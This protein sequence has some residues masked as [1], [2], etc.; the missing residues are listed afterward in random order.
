M[1]PAELFRGNLLPPQVQL[2]LN[3][4]LLMHISDENMRKEYRLAIL[5]QKGLRE[6]ILTYLTMQAE[7]RICL[8]LRRS[9]RQVQT[10]LLMLLSSEKN[11]TF[12]H[13]S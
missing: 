10:L 8:P 5:L 4:R 9:F 11:I 13:L 1:L 3:N 12:V 6:R 7:K 2:Q